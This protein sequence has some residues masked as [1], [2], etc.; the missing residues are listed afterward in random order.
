MNSREKYIGKMH[1]M[2]DEIDNKINE[3]E[4]K[5]RMTANDAKV[6]YEPEINSLKEKRKMVEE[7]IKHLKTAGE[8]A[9]MELK[10]GLENSA[11]DLQKTFKTAA[12]KFKTN[13]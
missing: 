11:K 5:L 2:I 1:K 9:W 3:L 7:K 8:G 10:A 12:S 6:K 4:V 13:I